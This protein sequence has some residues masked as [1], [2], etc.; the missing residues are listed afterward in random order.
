MRHRGKKEVSPNLARCSL[1][2]CVG[3]LML[4]I[5]EASKRGIT[6]ETSLLNNAWHVKE[7]SAC[8]RDAPRARGVP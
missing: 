7:T 3:P 2:A 6:L 5:K 8:F 1:H 4:H